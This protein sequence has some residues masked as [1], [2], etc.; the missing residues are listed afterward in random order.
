MRNSTK[1]RSSAASGVAPAVSVAIRPAI[2]RDQHL[3]E[4]QWQ[5]QQTG[6]VNWQRADLCVT[7]HESFRGCDMRSHVVSVPSHSIWSFLIKVG[8]IRTGVP[9]NLVPRGGRATGRLI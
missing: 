2:R 4:L 8:P 9:L 6:R 7:G 1:S 5:N 3:G